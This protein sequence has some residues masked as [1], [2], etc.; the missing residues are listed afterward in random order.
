MI[1]VV[2]ATCNRP[3]L[4]ERI[5]KLINF[6]SLLPKEIIIVDSSDPENYL[7]ITKF[8]ESKIN[9]QYFKTSIKSAAIQR[10]IALEKLSH[11]TSFLVILDDDVV[12]GQNYIKALVEN[13]K[14]Q[15]VVGVSGI[16]FNSKKGLQAH[17]VN[18]LKLL[19]FLDSRNPGVI[20]LSGVNIPV[21]INNTN[22]AILSEWL[23]GCSV[24]RFNAIQKLR[25]QNNFFGQSLFEDVIFSMAARK[26]GELIVDTSVIF[27]HEE[28]ELQRP[29][30]TDFY[31]MWIFNRYYVVLALD[32]N[33]TKYLAFHWTN[34]G[35]TI[36]VIFEI[37]C[38]KNSSL[39]KL[40][41]IG[42]GYKQ[43]LKN[44][45]NQ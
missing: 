41:G 43:L 19:F 44:V 37:L 13:F 33:F 26:K 32:K 24:W 30:Q 11:K 2:I 45:I 3:H 6:Q 4:C 14:R 10:N 38:F 1:S 18:L 25:F 17:G 23:I 29:N 34:F 15:S 12:I 27:E 5:I 22:K 20:T 21:H 8:I 7:D 35:K 42:L 28:S 9:I 36:Q 16:A 31:K 39:S 40:K